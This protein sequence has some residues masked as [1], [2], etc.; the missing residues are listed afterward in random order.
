M[1][2]V[3]YWFLCTKNINKAY[4]FCWYLPQTCN[5]FQMAW[6]VG[7]RRRVKMEVNTTVDITIIIILI[8]TIITIITSTRATIII[9]NDVMV[10]IIFIIRLMVLMC[11]TNGR[12]ANSW[13][14]LMSRTNGRGKLENMVLHD[15]MIQLRFWTSFVP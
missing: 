12:Q 2:N 1:T 4:I 15:F 8:T 13:V 7:T 5:C 11:I 14:T 3:L 10:V 6:M 9:V